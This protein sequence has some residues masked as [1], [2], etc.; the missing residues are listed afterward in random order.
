MIPAWIDPDTTA[1]GDHRCAHCGRWIEHTG[2][3]TT[4]FRDA[5]GNTAC[6]FLMGFEHRPKPPEGKCGCCVECVPPKN[7]RAGSVVPCI[8][9]G[10]LTRIPLP[11]HM[12]LPDW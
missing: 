9:C 4:G 11:E 5:D 12:R 10:C 2:R 3:G 6:P 7:P 8:L 1:T